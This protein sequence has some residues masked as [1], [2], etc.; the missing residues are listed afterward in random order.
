MYL[1]YEAV[2]TPLSVPRQYSDPYRHSI[3][4]GRRRK[5]AGMVNILDEAVKNV[6]EALKLN[7][8]YKNSVIIFTTGTLYE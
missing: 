7:G 2:H 3:I 5:Y 1:S 6:T 8:L 4:N